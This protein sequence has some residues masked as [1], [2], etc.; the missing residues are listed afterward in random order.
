MFGA[1]SASPAATMAARTADSPRNT[2]V[3]FATSGASPQ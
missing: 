1:M 3:T 2:Y